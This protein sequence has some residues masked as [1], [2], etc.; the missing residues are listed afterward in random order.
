VAH[1]EVD[2]DAVAS[3]ASQVAAARGLSAA[4]TVTISPVA[5]DP[6]STA[7]AHTFTAR[8]NGIVEYTAVAGAITDHRANMLAASGA[9]YRQQEAV[10]T[11]ALIGGSAPTA[12]TRQLPTNGLPTLPPP[13]VAAPPIG[14]PPASGKAIA[15][16]IHSGAGATGLHAA[17]VQI[18]RHGTDL[19]A[20]ADRLRASATSLS[21]DW[22]SAAGR[23]ASSRVT[24]LGA[25]YESHAAHANS[26]AAAV[27]THG[28]NFERAR[29]A[30]PPP[31]KFGFAAACS[32]RRERR[33][34]KA[35]IAPVVWSVRQRQFSG[36]ERC[37]PGDLSPETSRLEAPL[38]STHERLSAGADRDRYRSIS[39]PPA[40]PNEVRSTRQRQ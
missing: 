12:M 27:E 26:L 16:L 25:W 10:N 11:A 5:P 9:Q 33:V 24:E 4:P 1:V 22:D 18:R 36:S 29:T 40:R 35:P 19:S 2:P 8:M 38:R 6:V 3:T 23:E 7:V 15:H 34:R 31:E 20:R 28:D 14:A 32:S 21:G 17:A 13:T 30:V 37:V 39:T